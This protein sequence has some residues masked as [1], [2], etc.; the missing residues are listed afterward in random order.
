[1]RSTEIGMSE[2]AGFVKRVLLEEELDWPSAAAE[3]LCGD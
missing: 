1:M 3:R 2:G